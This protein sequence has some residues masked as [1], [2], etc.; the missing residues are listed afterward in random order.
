MPHVTPQQAQ[1]LGMYR[2]TRNGFIVPGAHAMTPA[3][4]WNFALT[5]TVLSMAHPNSPA[6]IYEGNNGILDINNFQ[7][8]PVVNGLRPTATVAHYP[9]CAAEIATLR[10]NIANAIAGNGAAQNACQAALVRI[11][12]RKN[13]LIPG[14]AN[15]RYRLHLKATTWFGWDHWALSFRTRPGRPRVYIQTVTGHPLRHACDRIWDEHLGG[16]IVNLQELH[17]AQVNFINMVGNQCV[18]CGKSHGFLPSNPFNA[19]HRCTVCSAVYCPIHGETLLGKREWFDRT[20]ACG[21]SGCGGR[22]EVVASI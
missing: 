14:V 1:K 11:V 17:A 15:D 5:G 12:A 3:A 20:R 13:G 6:E 8:P 7:I 10:S 21:Q 4:C 19:W 9:N 2:L 16:T 22:T 18:H